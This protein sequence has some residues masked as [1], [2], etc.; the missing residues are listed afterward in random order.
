[1][2][3]KKAK[4]AGTGR[5]SSARA[6]SARASS[7]RKP[8]AKQAPPSVAS[9]LPQPTAAQI[10]AAKE[11]FEQGILVRGEA[12]P[13]GQPLPPGATHE[14]VPAADGGPPELK[15]KRYSLR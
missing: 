2:A 13:A 7:G 4:A 14:I 1:M 11:K 15:R 8:A 5:P 9:Q 12:V 6:S 3:K 10:K